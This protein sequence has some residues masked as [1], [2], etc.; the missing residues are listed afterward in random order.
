MKKNV[1]MPLFAAALLLT[2]C[3]NADN[4]KSTSEVDNYQPTI[5]TPSGA[6][7][8]CFYDQGNNNK[9]SAEEATNVKAELLK[10]DTDLVVFDFYNGLK[11]IKAN[12][13]K[14]K[15]ARILTGGNLYLVGINKTT[16]PSDDDY[17]VSFGEGLLPDIAYKEIY[18]DN[19]DAYVPSAKETAA[20]L[21]SGLYN[22]NNVDYVITAQPVLFAQMNN[23]DASTYGNLHVVE[24]IKDSWKELTGQ[25]ILPQAGLFVRDD[26]YKDHQGSYENEIALLD[27]RIE[28]AIDDPQTVKDVM[29]ENQSLE[30]QAA[31][32]GFNANVAYGVQASKDT[33]NGFALVK[34]DV[35]VDLSAFLSAVGDDTDYSD[36]ML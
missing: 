8:I 15:L 20:V 18:G 35:E 13:A 7:A 9:F 2:S 21:S 23:K 4:N 24:A 22:G 10:N 26:Y 1:L 34:G 25:E 16:L 36:I 33:P 12:N 30:Q 29:N 6:P 27:E 19:V 32:F 3:G 28:T 5:M 17:I 11:L 31:T 14:Y